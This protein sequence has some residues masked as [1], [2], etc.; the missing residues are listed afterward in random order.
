MIRTLSPNDTCGLRGVATLAR[1]KKGRMMIR[2]AKTER[3]AQPLNPHA[4]SLWRTW[5]AAL[6]CLLLSACASPSTS[7]STT[8]KAGPVNVVIETTL[9]EV[10]IELDM[11]RA[12]IAASYWLGYIDRGQYDGA[13]LYRSASL[14]RQQPPQLVQGGLLLDALNQSR[15]IDPAEHGVLLQPE[16]ETTDDSGLTH[17]AGAVSLARDLVDTGH[18]IPEVVFCLRAAPS[19]DAGVRNVPDDR[20]FPVIGRVVSGIEVI[21]AASRQALDGPTTIPFLRGQILTDPVTILRAY[22]AGT[23]TAVQPR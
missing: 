14:D 7:N 4:C 23:K 13:T 6:G 8:T 5:V 22:R 1:T 16:F 2:Q 9:G 17:S 11:D 15:R 19:M 21:E 3:G 18:L 12:P 10:V 20:G